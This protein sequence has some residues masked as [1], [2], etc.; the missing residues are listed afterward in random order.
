M[1]KPPTN[2]NNKF[3]GYEAIQF[4]VGVLRHIF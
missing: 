3:F 1:S 4:I 2:K